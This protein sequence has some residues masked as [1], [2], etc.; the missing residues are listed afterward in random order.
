LLVSVS[1]NM[2]IKNDFQFDTE[3]PSDYWAKLFRVPRK[4]ACSGTSRISNLRRDAVEE[5]QERGKSQGTHARRKFD[6]VKQW[7]YGASA[8]LFDFL[9]PIIRDQAAND[10][11]SMNAALKAFPNFDTAYADPFDFKKMITQDTG[12]VSRRMLRKLKRFTK[13]YNPQ[14]YDISANAVQV[15]KALLSWKWRADSQGNFAEK[16]VSN[17][18]MNFDGRL[19]AREFILGSIIHNKGLI[20]TQLCQH[21][22]STSSNT[23]DAIFLYLDCNEN[24][25][26]SAEEFWMN[27]QNLKRSNDKYNIFSYGSSDSLRTAAVNDFIL[28]NGKSREGF[29]SRAEFIQGMLLGLWD[30]QTEKTGVVLDDS[31]TMK[32]FRWRDDGTTDIALFNFFKK[33]MSS[34]K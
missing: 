23:F 29:V 17:Y 28:K 19:D 32:S 12:N 21:C 25:W 13:N 6:W 2:Q 15:K 20:G 18:D 4:T 1:L 3:S 27:L 11:F 9:D 33:R 8:Y 14:I 34:H 16:F 31:R 5:R 30:R 26:L 7:G 24:G 22:Y 10:M